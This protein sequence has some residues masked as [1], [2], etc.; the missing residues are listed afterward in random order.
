MPTTHRP[1][2]VLIWAAVSTKAQDRYSIE[3]QLKLA[4]DWCVRSG[5]VIVDELIVRGFSR[6]YWTLSDV[7]TA[8][9]DD[10]D[11][12]AFAQLQEH[13]RQ[14]SF[15]LFL[16]FDAD[17]FGRTT[18]LVHEVI[19]RITRDVN[20][21]I[22]TLFDGT[23]INAENAPMIGTLKALK[24]Q[25]D[26]DRLKEYRRIGMNNRA[27]DGKSTGS[28]MPLFHRKVRDENGKEI[29][30]VVNEELRWLWTDLATLILD[31]WPWE[32]MEQELF[33][34]YGHGKDPDTPYTRDY[35]R[36]LV[37]HPAFWGH[38]ALNYRLKG[39]VSTKNVGPWIWDEAY[40]P[41]PG[42]TVYRN[43]LPAVYSGAWAALGEQVKQELT[44]RYG[45]RGK[46]R[47]NTSFRFSGL[48][49]CEE[50]GYALDKATSGSGKIIYMRCETP[51]MH[52]KRR[53]VS[54]TQRKYI[55]DYQIQEWF[56]T[57]FLRRGSGQNSE[58][59]DSL[60]S[61]ETVARQITEHERRLA[62]LNA[63]AE[64]LLTELL[65]AP[66]A[67]RGVYRAKLVEMGDEIERI[68][69]VIG[70][71]KIS[72]STSRDAVAAQEN[73]IATLDEHEEGWLWQQDERFIHQQLTAAL[74]NKRLA[75]RDGKIIGTMPA[76]RRTA[77]HFRRKS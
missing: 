18:S 59:F 14:K 39:G 44:R 21:R 31:G 53:T 71:L 66:D 62:T 72:L 69:T 65:D 56:E 11:M 68:N 26:V 10:P 25:Q 1:E 32:Q 2:Q 34:R 75:T 22:Y 60:T 37:T 33:H 67:L 50:C 54:C 77:P 30:V 6:D 48:L 49:I 27:R 28:R 41:P 19:G 8:A 15:S 76:R 64:S 9:A 23:W 47:S 17:R 24:A 3:D 45:L 73:L 52:N 46:A 40:E 5:A 36:H 38:N 13:I 35:M 57:Q 61:A 55:H 74:G 4:R 42:V 20:A 16:C 12:R 29:G 58:L 63:R 70:D 7:V 43:R 51:L